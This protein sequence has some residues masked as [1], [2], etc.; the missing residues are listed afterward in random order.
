MKHYFVS[1]HYDIRDDVPC[2][3][4]S[5]FSNIYL[6]SKDDEFLM[7][8][9]RAAIMNKIRNVKDIAI[10]YYKEIDEKTFWEN[11]REYEEVYK[12]NIKKN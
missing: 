12:N 8:T 4:R 1:Y 7:L 10:L 11:V 9:I 2:E 3:Q 5:G 6:E